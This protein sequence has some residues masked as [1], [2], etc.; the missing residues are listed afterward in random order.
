M[1]SSMKSYSRAIARIVWL[2]RRKAFMA[3]VDNSLQRDDP[4][5]GSK[6]RWAYPG[7]ENVSRVFLT[8]GELMRV[9]GSTDQVMALPML[10]VWQN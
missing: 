3:N 6:K 8:L 7:T 5:A 1:I 10:N 9:L 4:D 2:Q